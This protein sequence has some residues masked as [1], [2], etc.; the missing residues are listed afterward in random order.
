MPH[1]S[2]LKKK[3]VGCC[4]QNLRLI[5]KGKPRVCDSFTAN[6]LTIEK[7]RVVNQVR[8]GWSKDKVVVKTD[9]FESKWVLNILIW[10]TSV[11]HIY[12]SSKGE[13]I[14]NQDF[15]ENSLKPLI[16]T[17]EIDRPKCGAEKL[18]IFHDHARLHA[19]GNVKNVLTEHG[20]GTIRQ[21]PFSPDLA[22]WDSLLFSLIKSQ[23]V[24]HSDAQ[25]L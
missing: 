11:V 12:W 4:R 24:N 21:P 9:Q 5:A 2:S 14:K 3:R 16:T 18:Q 1:Q 6:G 17:S 7:L 19:H 13:A 10:K 15:I 20:I 22:S 23:L 8:Y 25:S